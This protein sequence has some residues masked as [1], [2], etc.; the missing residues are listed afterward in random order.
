M[1]QYLLT[2]EGGQIIAEAE[3]LQCAMMSYAG[4]GRLV[5]CQ[6]LTS[7]SAQQRADCRAAGWDCVS[8]GDWVEKTAAPLN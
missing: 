6:I 4:R 5:S 7:T 1:K 3:S 8:D 2:F